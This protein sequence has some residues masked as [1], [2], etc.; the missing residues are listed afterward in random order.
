MTKGDVFLQ[1]NTFNLLVLNKFLEIFILL[2][3]TTS[4]PSLCSIGQIDVDI[5]FNHCNIT[6]LSF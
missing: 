3:Y 4:F 5:R 6:K 1:K 2:L